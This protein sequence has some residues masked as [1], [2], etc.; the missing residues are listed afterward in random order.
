MHYKR[1]LSLRYMLKNPCGYSSFISLSSLIQDR[2]IFYKVPVR[3]IL[4][5]NI[6]VYKICHANLTSKSC[7]YSVLFFIENNWDVITL[8]LSDNNDTDSESFILIFVPLR[9]LQTVFKLQVCLHT[10]YTIMF[11]LLYILFQSKG[12]AIKESFDKICPWYMILVR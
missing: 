2:G 6:H 8:A 10:L 3:R 9:K 5:T 7:I 12:T 11:M 1:P 4:P